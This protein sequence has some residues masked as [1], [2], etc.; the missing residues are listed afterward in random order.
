M[1]IMRNSLISQRLPINEQHNVNVYLR[2][3]F[4]AAVVI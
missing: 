3:C 4:K 2:S 1:Q